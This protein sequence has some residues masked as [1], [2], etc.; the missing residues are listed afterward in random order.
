MKQKLT[1]F[2]RLMLKNSKANNLQAS[3]ISREAARETPALFTV[4][5]KWSLLLA[6]ASNGTAKQAEISL[7]CLSP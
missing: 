4:D 3:N 7:L 2:P 5:F 1:P 6:R